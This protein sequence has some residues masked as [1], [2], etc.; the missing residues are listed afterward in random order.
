MA[1]Y[2]QNYVKIAVMAIILVNTVNLPY[3]HTIGQNKRLSLAREEGDR[4]D[5][6][7][8]FRSAGSGSGLFRHK[9]SPAFTARGEQ[10]YINEY[11]THNQKTLLY[12]HCDV[13]L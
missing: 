12:I 1:K 2:T 4:N 5:V 11:V 3:M 10:T 9:L 7:I 6:R 13:A 8:G